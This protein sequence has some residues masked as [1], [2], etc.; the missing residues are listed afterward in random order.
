MFYLLE[1]VFL[2]KYFAI[3]RR[4]SITFIQVVNKRGTHTSRIERKRYKYV[5]VLIAINKLY[6][7]TYLIGYTGVFLM[8]QN[9]TANV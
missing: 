7:F 5:R 8:G 1:I 3:V 6:L 4:P 9:A 2:N